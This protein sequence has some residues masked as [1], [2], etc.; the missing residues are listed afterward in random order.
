MQ[1]EDLITR[2]LQTARQLIAQKKQS[3]ALI[4]LKKKKLQEGRADNID[5]WLLNVE[6]LVNNAFQH[7]LEDLQTCMQLST[8]RAAMPALLLP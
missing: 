1:L 4:T 8:A 7:D 2:E 6:E 3:Q 5:K